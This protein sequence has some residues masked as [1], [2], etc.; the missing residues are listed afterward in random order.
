MSTCLYGILG[1]ARDAPR[2]QIRRAYLKLAKEYHPDVS[3]SP[4]AQRMFQQVQESYDVLSDEAKRKAYDLQSQG[5]RQ[6]YRNSTQ[7]APPNG[8]S[9]NGSFSPF[10]ASRA[11]QAKTEAEFREQRSKMEAGFRHDNFVTSMSLTFWRIFPLMA[12]VWLVTFLL[13][14]GPTTYTDYYACM[15]G[16]MNSVELQCGIKWVSHFT[17]DTDALATEVG[18]LAWPAA[19]TF[20]SMA[21]AIAEADLRNGREDAAAVVIVVTDGRPLSNEMTFQASRDLRDKARL[22]W[23]PV[24]PNCPMEDMEGWASLPVH[25]NMI[26]LTD[27]AALEDPESISAIISDACPQVS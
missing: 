13:F 8:R 9:W 22:M 16:T 1:V 4:H 25:D 27:F 21:L 2:A 14:S 24:G 12:P 19:S 15:D 18:N 17:T 23:V 10:G 26:E 7:Q 20:T 11:W 6:R 5:Q 3:K